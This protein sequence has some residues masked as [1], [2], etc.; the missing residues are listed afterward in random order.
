M[1]MFKRVLYLTSKKRWGVE[2]A[3]HLSFQL[4]SKS[5]QFI[6]S[7]KCLKNRAKCDPNGI[8][9]TIFSEKKKLPISWGTLP[10]DPRL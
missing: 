4:T 9:N 2:G 6:S 7:V 5:Y 3:G 8:K 10:P 1:K